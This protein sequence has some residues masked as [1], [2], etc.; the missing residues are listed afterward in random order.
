MGIVSEENDYSGVSWKLSENR[1]ISEEIET[2]ITC[3]CELFT[4]A[5]E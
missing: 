4:E 5:S 1:E 2:A 3:N